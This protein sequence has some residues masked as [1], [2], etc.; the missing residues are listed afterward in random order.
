M[1]KILEIFHCVFKHFVQLTFRTELNYCPLVY[2]ITSISRVHNQLTVFSLHRSWTNIPQLSWYE[3]LIG[4]KDKTF[5]C[6]K[7]EILYWTNVFSQII[8]LLDKTRKK[9]CSLNVSHQDL[10]TCYDLHLSCTLAMFNIMKNFQNKGSSFPHLPA[11]K[12]T[13]ASTKATALPI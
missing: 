6:F 4:F 10:E 3:Y 11:T 2:P 7:A 5:L 12:S 9:S 1:K 8:L 13:V